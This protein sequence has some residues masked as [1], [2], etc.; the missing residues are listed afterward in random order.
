MHTLLSL[1]KPENNSRPINPI[2]IEGEGFHQHFCLRNF[3]IVITPTKFK[4]RMNIK[5]TKCFRMVT[6]TPMITH[7]QTYIC[8][9]NCFALPITIERGR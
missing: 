5:Y 7:K 6:E 4:L 1:R 3:S 2:T 9:K 8:T